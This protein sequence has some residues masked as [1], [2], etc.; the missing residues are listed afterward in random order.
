MSRVLDEFI[1]LGLQN[2]T[3]FLLL[4][5]SDVSQIS[6][7][8][9]EVEAFFR[10]VQELNERESEGGSR[11][12][13]EA[14]LDEKLHP[15]HQPF[16]EGD[17]VGIAH[18]DDEISTAA[19]EAESDEIA[20]PGITAGDT[21][22]AESGA[23]T[24]K[25]A[26]SEGQCMVTRAAENEDNGGSTRTDD[27]SNAPSEAEDT[28][29]LELTTADLNGNQVGL[30]RAKCR[31]IQYLDRA[32][33]C[34][35]ALVVTHQQSK[36]LSSA[37]EST[38]GEVSNKSRNVEQPHW[39]LPLHVVVIMQSW[40]RGC[41]QRSRWPAQRSSLVNVAK[42]RAAQRASSCIKTSFLGM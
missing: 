32:H 17:S 25:G 28:G 9:R 41:R 19:N 30:T 27:L 14:I 13:G 37:I 11:A 40:F 12:E 10:K 38:I 29:Q 24:H 35:D 31:L 6:L 23:V 7:D 1:E 5:R 8:A 39:S 22:E 15:P 3:D 21:D 33:I 34:F 36:D 18:D 2:V 20:I 26:R 4:R 42:F 16:T